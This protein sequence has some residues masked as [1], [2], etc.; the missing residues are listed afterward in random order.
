MFWDLYSLEAASLEDWD[1][2]PLSMIN[3][4][5][6]IMPGRVTQLAKFSAVIP[7]KMPMPTA[8]ILAGVGRDIRF[9]FMA[10]CSGDPIWRDCYRQL[11]FSTTVSLPK[12][13]CLNGSA[14]GRDS[15]G[16]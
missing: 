8:T 3:E 16:A 5:I 9:H 4:Y 1:A 11:G 12:L 13:I 10:P 15:N 2:I 6:D 14:E 7:S